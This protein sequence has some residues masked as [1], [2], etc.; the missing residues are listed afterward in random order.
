V[1]DTSRAEL[2]TL[3]TLGLLRKEVVAIHGTALTPAQLGEMG[4]AGMKLVWSPQSN[5]ALYGATTNIPAALA[6][7]LKVALA[8]DWT[9]SGT[10][11]LL[12]ELKVA[13]KLNREQWNGMLSDAQ[14][15]AMATS[16]PADIVGMGD[17]IGRIA[18]GFAADLVVVAANG[19]TPLRAVI[20]AKQADVLLTVVGGQPMY[21]APETLTSLGVSGFD[22]VTVCGQSRGLLVRDPTVASGGTETLADLQRIL[23]GDGAPL[24]D[25]GGSCPAQP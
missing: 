16:V 19:K 10:N 15:F 21:G 22:P 25:L 23:S 3:R 9:L 2:D 17:R 12:A 14:L 6:A 11:N 20:D 18:P 5:L 24:F 8:P 7:G 13:D 1:D 4:Q